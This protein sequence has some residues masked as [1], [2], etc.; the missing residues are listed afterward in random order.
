MCIHKEY[1]CRIHELTDRLEAARVSK[2]GE[3]VRFDAFVFDQV[4]SVLESVIN[5]RADIPETDRRGMLFEAVRAAGKDK[6][7]PA[8]LERHLKS[9]EGAYLRRPKAQFVLASSLS[10]ANTLPPTRHYLNSSRIKLLKKLPPT[11]SR[12][13]IED[14]AASLVSDCP[15]NL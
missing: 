4:V 2:A 12:S 11:F 7:D 13:A 9:S 15:G 6:L 5:F 3:S 8:G 14:R 10:I 1:R